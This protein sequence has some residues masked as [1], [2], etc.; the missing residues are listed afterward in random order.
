MPVRRDDRRPG[1]AMLLRGPLQHRRR[2]RRRNLRR[3]DRPSR[4]VRLRQSD[5][6]L[7][8]H[9][10]DLRRRLH[11]LPGLSRNLLLLRD[12][13][14][15]R[16][17]RARPAAAAADRDPRQRRERRSRRHRRRRRRPRPRRRPT[18]ARGPVAAP[19]RLH[20]PVRGGRERLRLHHRREQLPRR[21]LL[22]LRAASGQRRLPGRR[23]GRLQRVP[24]RDRPELPDPGSGR[25]RE[26][27]RRRGLRRG[28]QRRR[29]RLER[30]R[31]A[32]DDDDL[33][34]RR[35]D[36]GGPV[37][38]AVVV[39][40]AVAPGR[41]LSSA[42]FGAFARMQPSNHHPA[43]ARERTNR[44]PH[45][46]LSFSPSFERRGR[47]AFRISTR[48]NCGRG[49]LV[50]RMHILLIPLLIPILST[51]RLFRSRCL[52]AASLA[53]IAPTHRFGG[54]RRFSPTAH[55]SSEFRSSVT[56]R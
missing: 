3:R 19:R 24:K 28:G 22:R 7:R 47:V 48:K 39:D 46:S 31:R 36:G 55:P 14:R 1:P 34:L 16:A 25:R 41:E 2:R 29:D 44:R 13:V 27:R 43:A 9:R 42:P 8:Q 53:A 54:R 26:R 5:A 50:A 33:A 11:R 21:G 51:S 30:R 6:D 32:P 10:R 35:G 56:R 17:G 20:G 37:V 40:L 49:N 18:E 38:A 45:L 4:A 23:P 52:H 15:V 12:P